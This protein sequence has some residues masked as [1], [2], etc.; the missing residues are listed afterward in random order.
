[1]LCCNLPRSPCLVPDL[2]NS[3]RPPL[4]LQRLLFHQSQLYTFSFQAS[5]G[6][7][8]LPK[9]HTL[10]TSSPE[11]QHPASALLQ[12][13]KV[14]VFSPAFPN[15]SRL[16]VPHLLR[17]QI[18]PAPIMCVASFLPVNLAQALNSTNSCP[19]S[20]S[21]N[22]LRVIHFPASKL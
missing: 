20:A 17:A 5:Y 4:T 11:I 6:S 9:C 18:H 2:P 22:K 13:T 21:N 7:S 3:S 19:I 15:S 14:P 8:V 10:S 1:M 12:F 16:P